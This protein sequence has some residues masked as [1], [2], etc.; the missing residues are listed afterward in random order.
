MTRA[1]MNFDLVGRLRDRVL[2]PP[3]CE[4]CSD[5]ACFRNEGVPYIWFFTGIHEQYHTPADDVE[6]INFPGLAEIGEVSLRVLTRLAVMPEG[7]GL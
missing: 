3:P 2:D 4:N 1:M 7:L 6:W 5:F